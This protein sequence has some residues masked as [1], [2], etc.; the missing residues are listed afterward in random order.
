MNKDFHTGKHKPKEDNWEDK[1]EI[2][3][4]YKTNPQMFGDKKGKMIM[5]WIRNQGKTIMTPKMEMKWFELGEF[6]GI[7]NSTMIKFWRANPSHDVCK[8]WVLNK[9][10][11]RNRLRNREKNWLIANNVL[12]V[13]DLHPGKSVDQY[14]KQTIIELEN[15]IR[16][17][18]KSIF[19]IT[20][21]VAGINEDI[22]AMTNWKNFL[23]TRYYVMMKRNE[24]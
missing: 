24:C 19:S 18:E 13:E 9:K 2:A 12:R 4:I 3:K 7:S 1:Y 5:N 21:N 6:N 22:A 11:Q 15:T 16:F 20:E 23:S 8:K 10:K 17:L 14:Q